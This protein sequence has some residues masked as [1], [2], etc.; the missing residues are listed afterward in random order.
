[1]TRS[2]TYVEI[3]IPAIIPGSPASISTDSPPVLQTFRF[4]TDV[5]YLPG[6]IYAIPSIKSVDISPAIIS[7]G[8]NLGQRTIVTINFK[9]HRH[10][11]AT[12][13]YDSGTFWGK[14]RAFYGLKL[15]G[16]E[17]RLITGTLG[18]ALAQMETRYFLIE[19]TDGPTY[20]GVFKII[21]KDIIKLTDGDRALAPT[22]SNGELLADISETDLVA[23]LA[24][25]G[26]GD[27]EYAG[28]GTVA[29]GGKETRHL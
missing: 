11:F 12:E 22:M 29:I 4:T 21:A 20:D 3:D 10:I 28:S 8:E 16:Y 2:L 14:F 15:R 5:S 9:D 27:D 23:T 19:S 13:S 18:Q 1:M 7:L 24:P 17:L 25:P 6:D 26:I